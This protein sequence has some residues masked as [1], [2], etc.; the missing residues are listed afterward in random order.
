MMF[1]YQRSNLFRFIGKYF[2]IT[3]IFILFNILKQSYLD[4]LQKFILS[5]DSTIQQ[6]LQAI[7]CILI[8]T[9]NI[10]KVLIKYHILI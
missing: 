1:L 4:T 7:N 6:K 10:L 5:N 3:I 8:Y 9:K 2:M